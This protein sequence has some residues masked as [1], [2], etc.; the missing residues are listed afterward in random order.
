MVAAIAENIPRRLEF[1]STVKGVYET[2]PPHC[3][4]TL[5]R[6]FVRVT[7]V[8]FAIWIL[9]ECRVSASK[10]EHRTL[11]KGRACSDPSNTPGGIFAQSG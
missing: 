3:G 4:S 6:S 2:F 7:A 8:L 5:T 1:T 11:T 9:R 10:I